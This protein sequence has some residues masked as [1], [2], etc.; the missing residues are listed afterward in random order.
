MVETV[1]RQLIESVREF[2]KR[3]SWDE[4]TAEEYGL[5]SRKERDALMMMWR[6]VINV[7]TL[8]SVKRTFISPVQRWLR[9]YVMDA[10]GSVNNC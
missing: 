6:S 2:V 1:T 7:C 3:R 10:V 5:R 9:T 4:P 8:P